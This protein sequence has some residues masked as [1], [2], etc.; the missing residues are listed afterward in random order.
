MN[1]KHNPPSLRPAFTLIELLVTIGVIAVLIGIL[2]PMLAFARNAAKE[3]KCLSNAR[4]ITIAL[5]AFSASNRSRLPENRTLITS[6]TYITW[7]AQLVNDGSL[8]TPE[9]WQCPLHKDPGPRGEQGYSEGSIRCAGDVTAS[10]A[11]NG[12]ILWRRGLTDQTAKRADTI[13]NR[14]SHTILLAETNRFLADLRASD[15]IIANYYN[16]QPGPYAYWH[17]GNTGT[18]AFLDG[19]VERIKLLDTGSPDCR[20]HNGRDLSD[21]QFVPQRPNEIRPHDHPD[22]QYLVPSIY[23]GTD[24]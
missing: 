16:E 4:Q 13:I 19:H 9:V 14:P 1:R 5:N 15:P 20:W 8:P 2:L 23:L 24:L 22:W 21:D 11:I 17:R 12:H 3:S 10:Y 18:Y 6:N 7:R